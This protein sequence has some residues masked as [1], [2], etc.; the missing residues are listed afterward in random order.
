MKEA[1]RP[2]EDSNLRAAVRRQSLLDLGHVYV[3]RELAKVLVA[4][5]WNR[6]VTKR[7]FEIRPGMTVRGDVPFRPLALEQVF[8]L[9]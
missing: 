5:R 4:S 9:G 1:C 8:D 3:V 2:T 7:F 6:L